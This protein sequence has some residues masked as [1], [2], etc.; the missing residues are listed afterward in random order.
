MPGWVREEVQEVFARRMFGLRTYFEN[1]ATDLNG[2]LLMTSDSMT[3]IIRY[4]TY[5]SPV[6]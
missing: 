6:R 5:S 4:D 3:V 1:T 2:I